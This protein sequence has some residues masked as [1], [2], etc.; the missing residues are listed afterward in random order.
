MKV[1]VEEDEAK[2]FLNSQFSFLTRVNILVSPEERDN[3]GATVVH[4]VSEVSLLTSQLVTCIAVQ[5]GAPKHPKLQR[6]T[7]TT[8]PRQAARAMVLC[9]YSFDKGQC[10]N[11]R[12][13]H[14]VLYGQNP[15]SLGLEPKPAA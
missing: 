5:N 10:R 13:D 12:N 9:D 6:G 11:G 3:V 7:D 8:W 14:R 4:S 15:C 1:L 2:E